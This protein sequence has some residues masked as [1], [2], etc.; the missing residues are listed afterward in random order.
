MSCRLAAHQPACVGSDKKR[1]HSGRSNRS[2]GHGGGCRTRGR[3]PRWA[4]LVEWLRVVPTSRFPVFCSSRMG[5]VPGVVPLELGPVW[6][7][8][9]SKLRSTRPLAAAGKQAPSC[10]ELHRFITRAVPIGLTLNI[11]VSWLDSVDGKRSLPLSR[12]TVAIPMLLPMCFF[13]S[14]FFVSFCLQRQPPNG[15][16]GNRHARNRPKT[17]VFLGAAAH[18]AR[19]WWARG[20]GVRHTCRTMRVRQSKL[21][22]PK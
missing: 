1:L 20:G 17:R 16:L 10:W 2:D 6:V 7:R 4:W 5:I 12:L 14:C 8:S 19:W 21:S 3:R 11:D 13:C 9:R 22:S 18:E 15:D